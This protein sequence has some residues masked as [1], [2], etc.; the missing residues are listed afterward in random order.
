MPQYPSN[1]VLAAAISGNSYKQRECTSKLTWQQLHPANSRLSSSSPLLSRRSTFSLPFLSFPLFSPHPLI[2]SLLLAASLSLSSNSEASNAAATVRRWTSNSFQQLRTAA[3]ASTRTSS[4]NEAS[5]QTTQQR[6]APPIS[7]QKPPADCNNAQPATQA[8]TSTNTSSDGG[9][10]D[11][12][13]P[14]SEVFDK[15]LAPSFDGT[16]RILSD[17]NRDS[18]SNELSD[19]LGKV[20]TW[21]RDYC[22]EIIWAEILLKIIQFPCMGIFLNKIFHSQLDIYLSEHLTRF[23]ST[24]VRNPRIC[25]HFNTISR[26]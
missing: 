19:L 22:M 11:R 17:P 16:I 21:Y 5:N 20:T 1:F 24:R 8:A 18:D 25:P 6:P 26:A 14:S 12:L 9:C 2:S 15:L 3:A 13:S 7:N 4:N 23:D 10:S